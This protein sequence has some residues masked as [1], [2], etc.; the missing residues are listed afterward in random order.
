MPAYACDDQARQATTRLADSSPEIIAARQKL[1]DW[2]LQRADDAKARAQ[3]LAEEEP[4]TLRR[5]VQALL[6][7]QEVSSY[8]GPWIHPCAVRSMGS[9]MVQVWFSFGYAVDPSMRCTVHWCAFHVMCHQPCDVVG[10]PN[11]T[12]TLRGRSSNDERRCCSVPNSPSVDANEAL[13][14]W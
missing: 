6:A 7:M 5:H 13:A 4:Q 1:V 14:L 11:S 10:P 3:G 8:G 2:A 12:G 9:D